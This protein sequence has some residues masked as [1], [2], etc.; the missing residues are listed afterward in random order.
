ML[1]KFS[2]ISVFNA[3]KV[4]GELYKKDKKTFLKLKKSYQNIFDLPN[5]KKSL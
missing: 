2:D 3:D 1:Q 4:V 5:K